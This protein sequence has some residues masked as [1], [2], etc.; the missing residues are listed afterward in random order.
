[1]VQFPS[2][3]EKVELWPLE[4]Q[5]VEE[6]STSSKSLEEEEEPEPQLVRRSTRNRKLLERY[7]YYVDDWRCIF[8]LNA[9]IDELIFVEE[10]LGMK[11]AKS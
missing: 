8:S 6:S 10:A 7:G 11:D 9:N 1:M 3:P 4:R 5:E 2:M